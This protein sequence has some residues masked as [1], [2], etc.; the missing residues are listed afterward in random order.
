ML[1]VIG[2]DLL[3]FGQLI[4]AGM[5]RTT[6]EGSPDSGTLFGHGHNGFNKAGATLR[7]PVPDDGGTE[8]DH[9]LMPI[10]TPGSR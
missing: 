3:D 2:S 6:G 8:P 1:D 7:S 4:I 5:K 9:T 10:R